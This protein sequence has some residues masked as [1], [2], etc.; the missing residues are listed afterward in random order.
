MQAQKQVWILT[1]E[2]VRILRLVVVWTQTTQALPPSAICRTH[3]PSF[4]PLPW[5]LPPV[6]LSPS[7]VRVAVSPLSP[8]P[9]SLALAPFPVSPTLSAL[10]P[11]SPF[12]LSSQ[13]SHAPSLHAAWHVLPHAQQQQPS[14]PRVVRPFRLLECRR[15]WHE[16]QRGGRRKRWGAVEAAPSARENRRTRAA[17]RVSA[18]GALYI[19]IM[20][21]RGEERRRECMSA[22]GH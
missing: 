10:A 2:L 13:P 8:F 22:S 1:S 9:T 14:F 6:V 17:A 3:S 4:A 19:G 5:R 15:R 7:R 18:R 12:P 11:A 16:S 21:F 20:M